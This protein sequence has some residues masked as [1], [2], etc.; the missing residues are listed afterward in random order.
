MKFEKLKLF[1]PIHFLGKISLFPFSL[2]SLLVLSI[3]TL[4]FESHIH[5]YFL[6]GC[7]IY[8]FISFKLF[9]IIKQF[10]IRQNKID[11]KTW[12]KLHTKKFKNQLIISKIFFDTITIIFISINL[13]FITQQVNSI[14]DSVYN[15][16]EHLLHIFLSLFQYYNIRALRARK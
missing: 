1:S 2:A 7:L 5:I 4:E 11:Y 3:S 9:D 10:K 12:M 14:F 15:S 6:L 16:L 13:F 8:H